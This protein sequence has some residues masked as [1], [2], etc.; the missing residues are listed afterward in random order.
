[1]LDPRPSHEIEM[2]L[3]TPCRC[4]RLACARHKSAIPRWNNMGMD[5][6]DGTFGDAFGERCVCEVIDRLDGSKGFGE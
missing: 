4:W 6:D 5:V 2:R 1:M 3:E